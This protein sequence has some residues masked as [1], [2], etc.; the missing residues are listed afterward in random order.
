MHDKSQPCSIDSTLSVIGDRWTILILRD[1]FLVVG[2]FEQ[3]RHDIGI[4]KNF[5][6]DRLTKLDSA[7]I[8][9]QRPYQ[10]NPIRND[11]YLT[12]KGKDL[13]PSLIALMHWGDKWYADG[14]PPTILTHASAE[15]H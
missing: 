10:S 3:L 1:L 13:S 9:V 7:G 15:R 11:Y 6:S 14:N 5:L 2:I 4:E 12:E 8:I